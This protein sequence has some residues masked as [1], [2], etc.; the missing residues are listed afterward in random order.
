MTT[1]GEF[2]TRSKPLSWNDIPQLIDELND[3]ARQLLDRWPNMDSLQP[4]LL[5]DTALRRQKRKDQAWEDVTWE[6]RSH[7]FGQ[8]FRAMHEKLIE[9]RRH[10]HTKRYRAQRRVSV[11]DLELF[12][13]WRSWTQ[14]PDL[15]LALDAGL[16]RLKVDA[17]DLASIVEYRF[18]AGLTWEEVARMMDCSPATVQ[19]RWR[20][21]RLIMEES[22]QDHLAREGSGVTR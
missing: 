8:V 11:K 17:P 4:T 15:A 9:Y 10:Q 2:P 1:E 22:I 14:D 6:T 20:Q 19:R 18:F 3:V 7:F 13:S 12:D 16:E 5:V 21:I